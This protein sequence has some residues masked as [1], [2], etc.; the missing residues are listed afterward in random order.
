MGR[1]TVDSETS[2][3]TACHAAS[4]LLRWMPMWCNRFGQYSI[5]VSLL[6]DLGP[7]KSEKI[8]PAPPPTPHPPAPAYCPVRPWSPY[9]CPV[10]L[11][12]PLRPC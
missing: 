1:T 7:S 6:G 3:R 11:A 8:A 4:V 2:Q 10:S 5:K 12:W 9:A